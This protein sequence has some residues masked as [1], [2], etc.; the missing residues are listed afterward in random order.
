MP[1][2]PKRYM[3]AFEGIS[4]RGV[5][6]NSWRMFFKDLAT[7]FDQDRV[8]TGGA[9]LAYYFLLALFPA[10]LFFLTLLPYLPVPNLEARILGFIGSALP[11]DAA[12]MVR[13]TVEEVVTVR[14][15]GLLSFG[16]LFTLY[17]ATNGVYALMRE[18]NATYDVKEGRSFLRV[19]FTALGLTLAFGGLVIGA[20]ALVLLGESMERWLSS[21]LGLGEPLLS[22]FAVLR[23]AVIAVAFTAAFA[24]MYYYGPDV[25][26]EFRFITPGSVIGVITVVATTLGFKFYVENFGNYNATYGSIGAVIVLMLWLQLT[27]LIVLFGSEVNALIEHYSPQG[28]EKG[29]KTEK[30]AAA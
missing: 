13:G 10:L 5:Y 26:Q 7:E 20:F 28:K 23:W 18:L 8:T 17:A 14:K 2:A 30:A 6:G 25:E 22:L 12:N 24:L 27:G 16:I 1:L 3:G 11:G 19:R 29:K 4:L 9:A 15:G 21:Q